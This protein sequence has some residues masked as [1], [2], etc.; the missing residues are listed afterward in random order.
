[1]AASKNALPSI[2]GQLRGAPY[3][4]SLQL[5]AMNRAGAP[6][7]AAIARARLRRL[8]SSDFRFAKYLR[9]SFLRL[10]VSLFQWSFARGLALRAALNHRGIRCCGPLR[11]ARSNSSSTVTRSPTWVPDASRTEL[12]RYR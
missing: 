9:I 3:R 11:Y 12:C 8:A 5:R 1:M 10:G 7:S 4:P 6:D 2:R